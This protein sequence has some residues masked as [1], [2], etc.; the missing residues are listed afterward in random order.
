MKKYAFILLPQL[1]LAATVGTDIKM[2]GLRPILEINVEPHKNVSLKTKVSYDMVEQNV[3]GKYK[4]NDY[5]EVSGEAFVGYE[6][7]KKVS[8]D[9]S[10]T[11][12]LESYLKREKN[13]KKVY[14]DIKENSDVS[15][16]IEKAKSLKEKEIDKILNDK[17]TR[18]DAYRKLLDILNK[19]GSRFGAANKQ[20]ENAINSNSL[21]TEASNII[22]VMVAINNEYK[23][24]ADNDL[25]AG[26]LSLNKAY[27][28]ATKKVDDDKIKTAFQ[29]FYNY[30]SKNDDFKSISEDFKKVAQLH[31][32]EDTEDFKGEIRSKLNEEQLRLEDKIK[33]I[34]GENSNNK[35]ITIHHIY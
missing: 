7:I 15:E 2:E 13:L 4:V 23:N 16:V 10:K 30:F 29:H 32:N 14:N 6:N 17:V 34:E 20:L 25:K 9:D 31:E 26:P 24:D 5:V 12:L 19:Q 8:N 35:K 3:E 22:S 28:K 21:D 27:D 18:K 33:E 1:I 11:N